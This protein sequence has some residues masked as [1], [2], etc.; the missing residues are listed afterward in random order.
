MGNPSHLSQWK[1]LCHLKRARR[2]PRKT[3]YFC[4]SEPQRERPG[5]LLPLSPLESEGGLS[6]LKSKSG[7]LHLSLASSLPPPF[8]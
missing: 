5:S 7:W 6:S 1:N 2:A 3:R 4:K 8:L